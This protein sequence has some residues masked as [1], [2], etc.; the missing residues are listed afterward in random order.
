MS[1][2]DSNSGG[3]S[4]GGCSCVGIIL[5]ILVVTAIGW[6][7][8]MPGGHKYNIDIFPPRIWDMNE[9]APVVSGQ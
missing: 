9:V 8:P 7:L 6:G 3:C 5:L 1:D 4:C 2:S